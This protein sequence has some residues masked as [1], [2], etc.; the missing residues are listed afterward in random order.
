MPALRT[1]L[2]LASLCFLAG[3]SD[4]QHLSVAVL[5]TVLCWYIQVSTAVL[6]ITAKAKKKEKEK[7]K[8]K[9]EEEKMEV[10]GVNIET[11]VSSS[12]IF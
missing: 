8:E 9:K 12:S 10:V 1:D 11:F 6:S 4:A 7:E 2:A 3:G 5:L